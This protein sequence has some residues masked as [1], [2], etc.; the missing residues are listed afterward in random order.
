VSDPLARPPEASPAQLALISPVASSNLVTAD[1][2]M[3][4]QVRSVPW[5]DKRRF[6]VRD[7][8]TDST[9][10]IRATQNDAEDDIIVLN[11]VGPAGLGLRSAPKLGPLD[12]RCRR[13]GHVSAPDLAEDQSA[14]EDWWLCARCRQRLLGSV[15]KSPVIGVVSDPLKEPH[16]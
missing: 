1:G 9:L 2:E 5:G 10:A 4:Y 6:A 14:L 13:C 11:I 15:P 12:R 7:T 8:D 16:A 3:R